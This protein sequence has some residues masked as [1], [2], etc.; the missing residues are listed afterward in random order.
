MDKEQKKILKA[1]FKKNEQDTI[2][3]SIPMT[4]DNLKDLMSFLNRD[5][6]PECKHTLKQSIQFI[7]SRQLDT[8]IIIPWLGEHGGFCDCEVIS[9]VYDN[10]GDIIGWHLD[11][12]T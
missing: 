10:V 11:E 2:R 12:N 4:I 8:N 3:A 6:A 5:S 7:E 9:N 1:Q